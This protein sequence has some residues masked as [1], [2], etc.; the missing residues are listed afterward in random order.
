MIDQEDLKLRMGHLVFE[1]AADP[2]F[3]LDDSAHFIEVNQAACDHTGYSRDELL[4]MS[5][6]D[7]DAP[8]SKALIPQ[9]F[10]LLRRDGRGN[11]EAVHVHRSGRLIPV[12]M[13]IRQVEFEGKKLTLNI[14]RDITERKKTQAGNEEIMRTLQLLKVISDS[15]NDAIFA[16]DIE[17]R[18][19][20]A[21]RETLREMGK[22]LEDIIARKDEEVYSREN[23]V[24]LKERDRTV[25]EGRNTLTFEE[26]LTTTD[27]ERTFLTTKGPLRDEDGKVYGIFGISRDIT[28]RKRSLFALEKSELHLK[29]AQSIAHIGSWIF[30]LKPPTITWSDELYRIYGVSPETFIPTV[31]GLISLIHPDDRDAMKNWIEACASSKSPE[32]LEF[33]VRWPDGTLRHIRG[34]GE[35]MSDADGTSSKM[36]GTAQDITEIKRVQ[37]EL[38]D[39]IRQLEDKEHVKARFL[40]A[41]GHDLRQPLAAAGLFIEALKFTSPTP[42]Q[43]S[44]IQRLDLTMDTFRSLLDTLL[45]ISKLDAGVIKPKFESIGI[46]DIKL[47]LEQNFVPLAGEKN[48]DFKVH[49]PLRADGALAVRSDFGLIQSVLM[50]L[51]S[52]AIKFTPAGT[53]LVGA[54]RR[55]QELLFQVWDT[56]IGISGEEMQHIFDEFYQADNPQRDRHRGLGL[57]LAIAKRTLALLGA[58]LSC[59]S[60]KGLGSIFEFR[61]PLVTSPGGAKPSGDADRDNPATSMASFAAGKRFVVLEDDKLVAE[62]MRGLLTLFGGKVSCFSSADEALS[63]SEIVDADYYIVDYMLGGGSDGIEFLKLLER[64]AAK[65]VKAVVMTGDTSSGLI[66]IAKDC[67]WPV[68]HKPCGM[69]ELFNHLGAED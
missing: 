29:Q 15:S 68:V 14:C 4:T 42:E 62:G 67:R 55:G 31:E 17:G 48:L 21:N 56:G 7:I 30:D 65:P 41:A 33:R 52:N 35:L 66:R 69:P 32:A 22:P 46:G 37:R 3:V 20:Y 26:V 45:N 12:E 63:D 24:E 40:A 53:I 19:I 47:W 61:L 54:R 44:I 58:E 5:P 1:C 16:K 25:A 13:N 43:V 51:V 60:R 57:G 10:E 49:F 8:Q 2:I 11:F 27:G 50:N 36:S 28:E 23:A 9:R 34:Q 39:S 6:A 64:I 59:R 38:V 18:Y